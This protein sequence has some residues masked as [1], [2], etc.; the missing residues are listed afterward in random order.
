MTNLL[1]QPLFSVAPLGAL[2]LPGVMAALARDEADGFPALRPHQGMF[3]H[4]FL[5]QLG[6]LAL[7]GAGTADIPEDEE[8]WRDLLRRLTANFPGDEPWQLVV[9]D[10]TKPAFLQAPVPKGLELKNDVPTP[11]AL[12]LLITSKNHDLKQAVAWAG[13]AEDWVFALLALQ[14]G[15]GY[16]GAGNQGIVRM[17]GGSSSR[18]MLT[19]A[20]A[21]AAPGRAQSPRPGLWF[22]RD[23]RVLLETRSGREVLDF[24]ERGGRG[25]VWL[26]PWG[27]DD[28]LQ[29][30]ELDVWFIEICRRVRLTQA[31]GRIGAVK[32]TSKATRIDGKQFKGNVGDPWAPVHKVEC[33]AF[34]LGDEG[35]FGFDKLVD[36]LFSGTWDLPLLA[37]PAR[38][39]TPETP[40]TVVAQALARGNSKTGGFKSRALPLSGKIALALW[41]PDQRK[42]LH[43]L[44]KAQVEEIASFDK[45]LSYALVLAVAGGERAKISPRESYAYAQSAR[46]HLDR[47]ADAM[48]FASLWR[49]YEAADDAARDSV[50]S[51]FIRDLWARTRE[52]FEDALPAMPCASL[53]RPRAEAAASSA[54]TASVMK[55]YSDCLKPP[56]TM[57]MA[58]DAT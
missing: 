3:W 4:M 43:E 57:E 31:N 50:R 54:L 34:T 22:R 13:G 30:R 36:L 44:A 40:L 37:R 47:C 58:H 26:A 10:W 19:L 45:A 9:E 48:F 18:P 6:A 11:D 8:S 25:L 28:Q 16:G 32:G 21:A 20:P 52:I 27:E 55:S 14:T 39:E 38:F 33:K 1:T 2:T 7:H 12:D 23:V 29:A 42:A 41:S 46:D 15:E 24:P 53:F 5:V 35:D 51:D 49:R 56:K 17:N